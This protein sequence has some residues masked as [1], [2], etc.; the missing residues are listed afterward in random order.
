MN[1]F[2]VIFSLVIIVLTSGCA[3]SSG[4]IKNSDLASVYDGRWDGVYAR[5]SP[6]GFTNFC[7]SAPKYRQIRGFSCDLKKLYDESLSYFSLG[8]AMPMSPTKWGAEDLNDAVL[9]GNYAKVEAEVN[10]LKAEYLTKREVENQIRIEQE[11][12]VKERRAEEA[13]RK[14]EQERQERQEEKERQLELRRRAEESR[15]L[16]QR[17]HELSMRPKKVG[18]KVCSRDNLHGFVENVSGSKIQVRLLGKVFEQEVSRH[19]PSFNGIP[20]QRIIYEQKK[21]KEYYFFREAQGAFKASVI[22]EIHW[23]ESS[24][25]AEC[26]FQINY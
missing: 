5:L 23:F 24:E 17:F 8:N 12:Y 20:S 6:S 26:S 1:I 25:F 10:R 22:N 7:L 21:A 19:A 3:S 13:K 16:P 2:V 18:D 11:R 4:T 14:A 15:L 9:G